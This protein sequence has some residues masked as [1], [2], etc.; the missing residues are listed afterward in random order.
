[1]LNRLITP[2]ATAFLIALITV[3]AQAH[4]GT[5]P[6]AATPQPSGIRQDALVFVR[7]L[8]PAETTDPVTGNKLLL[9]RQSVL[10]P[11]CGSDVSRVSIVDLARWDREITAVFMANGLAEL[12][13]QDTGANPRGA[14]VD[15]VFNLD[16]S[17]PPAP[18][19][20]LR[21]SRHTSN[22]SGAI[23]SR[24]PLTST[25]PTSAAAS[26]ERRAAIMSCRPTRRPAMG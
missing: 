20:H 8:P 6:E 2:T 19:R 7:P 13:E 11:M 12:A 25:S 26:S 23:P 4:E 10:R 24:L 1:M 9:P 18:S 3:P 14:A 16:G 22:R 17:V 5:T 15:V 21:P